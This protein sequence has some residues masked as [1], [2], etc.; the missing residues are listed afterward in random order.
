[1]SVSRKQAEVLGFLLHNGELVLAVHQPGLG[2]EYPG[3]ITWEDFEREFF[4]HRPETQVTPTAA[5]E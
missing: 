2:E 3:G 5:E 1:V 4:R